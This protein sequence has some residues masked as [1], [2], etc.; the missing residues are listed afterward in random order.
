MLKKYNYTLL[1]GILIAHQLFLYLFDNCFYQLT[2]PKKKSIIKKVCKNVK[3]NTLHKKAL[4]NLQ[5][6]ATSPENSGYVALG[7]FRRPGR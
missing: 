7:C 5:V 1:M 3:K 4:K 2:L 6:G